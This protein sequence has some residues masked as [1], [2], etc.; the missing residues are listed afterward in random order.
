MRCVMQRDRALV[1]ELTEPNAIF[2]C[3]CLLA[4]KG[5]QHNVVPVDH[6]DMP[7][8]CGPFIQETLTG[9]E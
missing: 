6:N 2:A 7:N 8:C 1:L 5:I 3:V 9:H 4:K